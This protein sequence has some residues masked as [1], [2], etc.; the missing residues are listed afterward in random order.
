[1]RAGYII[2]FK[3]KG[4]VSAVLG[5]I[6][7]LFDHD[8]DGWGWHVAIA[9]AKAYDGWFVV[10]ACALGVKANYYSD[11]YLERN[12]RAWKWFETPL[13]NEQM[14]KFLQA[15]IDKAYDIAIYFWTSVA[16]IVRH[17]FNHPI[18]KLLDQRF[19]CWELVAEFC[20]DMGKPIVSKYDVVIISDIVK[21]LKG[22]LYG[23]KKIHVA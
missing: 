14:N 7:K 18:P 17:Y 12:T 11:K 23:K 21:A 9:W 15:N 10:E 16:I 19:S 8:Y 5:G 22:E 13:L 4:I 3:R 6:L 1:M 2:E 20:A